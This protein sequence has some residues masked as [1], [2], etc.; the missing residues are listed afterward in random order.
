MNRRLL[1]LALMLMAG[2]LF[3]SGCGQ[4]SGARGTPTFTPPTS[5]MTQLRVGDTYTVSLDAN[6]ATENTWQ[7][8]FDTTF[9]ELGERT[10]TPTSDA[11]GPGGE[12]VFTFRT[13]KPGVTEA[14]FSY[15]RHDEVIVN[16]T[17]GVSLDETMG[18]DE[19]V[20]I[21]QRS[22]CVEVGTLSENATLNDWTGTWWIDLNADKDG[23]APACVVD[24]ADRTAEVN[25]RCTGGLPAKEQETETDVSPAPD[26]G[27]ARDAALA[28]LRERYSELAPATNLTWSEEDITEQG[29]VGET[30]FRY[31]AESWVVVV[32]FPLVNPDNTV[33][34]VEVSNPDAGRLWQG[35][36]DAT[37]SVTESRA[38]DESQ[39]VVCWG[40]FIKSLPAD[41]QWD[42]YLALEGE[43]GVGI[44]ASDN[45]VAAQ[46]QVA[47]DSETFV[48]VWGTLHCPS[49]DYGGCQLMVTRLYENEP[50]PLL[51]P[52][53]I[54]DWTGIVT[55]LEFGAQHDDVFTLTGDVPVR[56]G[57]GST[58]PELEAQVAELR[59]TGEM[60]RIWGTVACGVLDVNGAHIEV[61]RIERVGAP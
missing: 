8:E 2:I 44:E 16:F 15:T 23:C 52:E 40:G 20:D 7:V 31:T 38:L 1:T 37:G 10:H 21:A 34:Q 25:W 29:L 48:H 19:A 28:Y 24:I 39:P 26:P 47:R 3:L 4:P 51:D 49:L 30:T 27:R 60:A 46:I 14:Y 43:N 45:T 18:L 35:D 11:T 59:D 50:G 53:P 57:I 61:T 17:I 5:Y 41:G 33:Y 56:F 6:A 22:V 13:L 32:S 54:E 42:D 55:S 58:I 12:E 9:L 36:V